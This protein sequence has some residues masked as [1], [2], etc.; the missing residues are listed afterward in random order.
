[1]CGLFFVVVQIFN[2]A[3]M[4][5]TKILY[6]TEMKN[7]RRIFLMRMLKISKNCIAWLLLSFCICLQASSSRES[8]AKEDY[9]LYESAIQKAAEKYSLD[10]NL[11]KAVVWQE[12]RF[13]EN[14]RGKCN[15]IG[16]MQIRKAVVQDWCK[17]H[18][19][20][21]PSREELFKPEVNLEIGC[22]HLSRAVSHWEGYTNQIALALCEYNAGRTKLL[23]W[24][25]HYGS[26]AEVLRNSPSAHYARSVISVQ[27]EYESLEEEICYVSANP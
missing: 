12:S 10:E 1:M 23:R 4:Q 21:M 5:N 20:Q 2:T 14:A 9:I 7:G 22:W 16:L 8:D 25:S 19:A 26:I 6:R 27:K 18:D 17:A 15:E 24:I 3:P 13:R 11:V